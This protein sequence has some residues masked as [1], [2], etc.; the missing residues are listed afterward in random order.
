M[1]GYP[2]AIGRSWRLNADLIVDRSPDALFAAE[3]AL[4]CLYRNVTQ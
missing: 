3:I 4:G 1:V 2:E